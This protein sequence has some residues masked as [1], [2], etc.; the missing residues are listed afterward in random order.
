MSSVVDRLAQTC[1]FASRAVGQTRL[2]DVGGKVQQI[3]VLRL[4][5]QVQRAFGDKVALFHRNGAS[6]ADRAAF[7][8]F[9]FDHPKAAVGVAEKNQSEDG[10]TVL[11]GSQF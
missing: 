5:G 2:F 11:V 3:A 8:D 9:P 1:D 4:F 7:H 10:H 6:V